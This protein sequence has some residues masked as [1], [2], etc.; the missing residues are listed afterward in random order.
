VTTAPAT[1]ANDFDFLLG[2][3]RIS[4]R[5][6]KELLV[7]S[8]EWDEFPSTSVAQPFFD[9]AG[10]F[11]LVDFPTKGWKGMSV[12]L[13]D[14]ER[15]EWTIY[16]ANNRTGLLQAPVVGRFVDGR[17]EFYG[18]DTHDATPEGTP[19]RARYLWTEI[20][21]RSARWE[22]AFSVDGERTWETNWIMELERVDA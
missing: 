13:F 2:S 16:W 6:L 3:W 21:E 5:R 1:T 8:D 19:V 15:E 7:G 9:G 18:D 11:E 10:S 4:N 22:Q 12:R 17:G 20:T 14:P